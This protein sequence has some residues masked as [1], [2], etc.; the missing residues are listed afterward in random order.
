MAVTIS[1]EKFPRNSSIASDKAGSAVVTPDALT[2]LREGMRQV[3]ARAGAS[4]KES[5]LRFDRL[6]APTR[7]LSNLN[8][9]AVGVHGG[10]PGAPDQFRAAMLDLVG[11]FPEYGGSVDR[12]MG[13]VG[14]TPAPDGGGIPCG[15]IE[16]G[17]LFPIYLAAASVFAGRRDEL[18]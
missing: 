3:V 4:P 9:L 2:S 5:D 15:M 10:H 14:Y 18:P 12:L 7:L 6:V 16:P 13:R 17:G 1:G 8:D 11:R